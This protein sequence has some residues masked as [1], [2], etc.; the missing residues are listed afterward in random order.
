MSFCKLPRVVFLLSSVLVLWLVIRRC[1]AQVTVQTHYGAIMGK[2]EKYSSAF[3]PFKVVNT[4]L[5][6]PY[7]A[8]PVGKLRFRPPKAPSPWKPKVY[9][10]S[11]FRSVCL[12]L[13]LKQDML[14]YRNFWPE[15]TSKDYSEDCLYLN[16]YVPQRND[17]RGTGLPV[18]VYIHGGGYEVGAPVANPGDQLALRGLVVV[19]IQYRLS[20]F[21]F[22]TTGDS[23]A[24]GNYGILDQVAA[25]KWVNENIA[26]FGGD[27]M[28]VT[29][30]GESAGGSSV[31]LHLLSPLSIGLFRHAISISGVDFSPFS[32][33]TL[34]EAVNFTKHVA[35]TLSC[36]TENSA[37]LIECLRG[38]D[39]EKIPVDGFN[40][41]RPVIDKNFLMDDPRELR[42]QGNFSKVPFMAGFT[43]NE[44]SF[45]LRQVNPKLNYTHFNDE[46]KEAFKI[47]SNYNSGIPGTG[48]VNRLIVDALKFQYTP[49][50]LVDHAPSL[51]QKLYDI[52]TDYSFAA[53]THAVLSIH[54]EEAQG[55]M[56]EFH[57]NSSLQETPPMMHLSD[58]P[59]IFGMPL[60]NFR[61]KFSGSRIVFDDKDRNVS[62]TII[63]LFTNFAKYGHPTPSPVRGARWEEFDNKNKKYLSIKL[64]PEMAN[65]FEPERMAFWNEFYPKLTKLVG[66]ELS[67]KQAQKEKKEVSCSSSTSIRLFSH[68]AIM[69]IPTLINMRLV[70]WVS[71]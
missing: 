35:K 62:D 31:A 29:I 36:P 18:M 30:F 41:W 28:K 12:Q 38:V 32:Y 37:K 2:S 57:Y 9:N 58:L 14:F 50:P 42:K 34:E 63:T 15:F 6:I 59:Y 43:K 51:I 67:S 64:E 19:T 11:Q 68:M 48:I 56:Y 3:A 54:T 47:V 7:A 53:P 55:F 5:G 24:A 13:R 49:R 25:L 46:I 1:N 65:Y 44:G 70:L 52:V 45:F 27:P 60:V 69:L 4:F 21:G 66:S 71:G 40:T 33:S 22:V 26:A 20:A 23:A 61:D 16:V 17:T 8:P 10:A 39:A